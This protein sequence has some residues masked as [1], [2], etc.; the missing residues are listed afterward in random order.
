[1]ATA[2]IRNERSWRLLERVGMRRESQFTHDQPVDGE[3]IADYIYAMGK[4]GWT[5]T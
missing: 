2:D 4:A 3:S 5:A 1:M